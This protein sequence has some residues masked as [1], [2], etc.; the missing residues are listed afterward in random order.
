[1]EGFFDKFLS[2]FIYL[3]NSEKEKP[4]AIAVSYDTGYLKIL[5][6]NERQCVHTQNDVSETSKVFFIF[7]FLLHETMFFKC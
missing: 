6:K 2:N 3:S 7:F 1:M 4:E 5:F